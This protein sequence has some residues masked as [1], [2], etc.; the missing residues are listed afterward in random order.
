M[1]LNATFQNRNRN[2]RDLHNSF[3]L[4]LDW[5]VEK[6]GGVNVYDITKYHNYPTILINQFF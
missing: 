1:V 4:V 2:W 6:S 3:G 5:I